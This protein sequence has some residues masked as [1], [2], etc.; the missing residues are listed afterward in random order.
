M[1]ARTSVIALPA[2]FLL[3]GCALLGLHRS[4][5]E[6]QK[7]EDVAS[8][9]AHLVLDDGS[10]AVQHST[11]LLLDDGLVLTCH[12]SFRRWQKGEAFDVFVDGKRYRGK[13]GPF[14]S[15]HDLALVNLF[16]TRTP[17]QPGPLRLTR[18]APSY[19]S[20]IVVLGFPINPVRSGGPP[21]PQ[22]GLMGDNRATIDAK[23][24]GER[25]R[26]ENLLE[27][28]AWAGKGSSGSPVLSADGRTVGMVVLA[29][30]TRGSWSG[31][32]Y[33]VSAAAIADFLADHAGDLYE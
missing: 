25:V 21:V 3:T 15:T 22:F 2:V 31:H 18:E 9:T 7:W 30:R 29:L 11:G 4:S 8:R 13:L 23:I 32:T 12:H 17:P 33:A 10:A 6:H 24:E 16:G 14:D 19:G 26:L 5:W 20:R 1:T 27:L 28:T